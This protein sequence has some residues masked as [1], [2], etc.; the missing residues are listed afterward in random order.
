MHVWFTFPFT[1]TLQTTCLTY[2]SLLPSKNRENAATMQRSDPSLS[3]VGE[4]KKEKKR[5]LKDSW[6]ASRFFHDKPSPFPMLSGG[7]WLL[8]LCKAVSGR[9]AG[10]SPGGDSWG[11]SMI[12]PTPFRFMVKTEGLLWM[13]VRGPAAHRPSSPG[14]PKQMF[15]QTPW[16]FFTSSAVFLSLSLPQYGNVNSSF[17]VKVLFCTLC[18]SRSFE[19]WV[20]FKFRYNFV[21]FKCGICTVLHT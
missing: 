13:H 14:L 3:L 4:K 11:E 12:T 6:D 16:L 8:C 2:I 19:T 17:P 9:N 1:V 20:Y 10:F 7:N 5:L 15:S 21:F 18:V